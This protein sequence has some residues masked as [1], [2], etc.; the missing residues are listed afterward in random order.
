MCVCD[1]KVESGETRQEGISVRSHERAPK[2]VQQYL[3]YSHTHTQTH[4]Q[5]QSRCSGW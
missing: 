3:S 2:D 5:S 1:G 4:T